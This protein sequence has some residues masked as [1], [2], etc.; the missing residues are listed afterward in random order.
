MP[1]TAR[2]SPTAAG[3]GGGGGTKGL[4]ECLPARK[5]ASNF[6][7]TPSEQLPYVSAHLAELSPSRAAIGWSVEPSTLQRRS[8]IGRGRIRRNGANGNLGTGWTRDRRRPGLAGRRCFTPGGRTSPKPASLD[9]WL[10]GDASCRVVS[11][12]AEARCWL[13]DWLAVAARGG[14]GGLVF[15]P[16]VSGVAG[17]PA[18]DGNDGLRWPLRWR[19]HSSVPC[20]PRPRTGAGVEE[21]L[22]QGGAVPA[23]VSP[24]QAT[25]GGVCAVAGRATDETQTVLLECM[26]CDTSP[27]RA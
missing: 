27:V 24:G 12:R 5:A 15:R 21:C 22:P 13:T 25:L 20:L 1:R 16:C 9:G 18:G 6:A 4:R 17:W 8:A 2:S 11:C 26:C 3:G 14:G 19:K 23:P 10:A 7:M